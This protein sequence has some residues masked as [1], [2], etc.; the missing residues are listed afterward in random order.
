MPRSARSSTQAREVR[1]SLRSL[2]RALAHPLVLL[3]VGAAV[4]SY[5]I[6]SFTRRWQDHQKE[7]ELK[8]ALASEISRSVTDFVLN[9]Q[10]VHVRA[11]SVTQTQLDAA[12]RTWSLPSAV[13]ESR[14]GSY[15][16]RS[17]IGLQ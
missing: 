17:G 12:Y 3:L 10:F 4:S 14:L 2:V 16:P 6:P 13:I 5:L 1:N 8:S 11:A 9:V 7:L 15:F